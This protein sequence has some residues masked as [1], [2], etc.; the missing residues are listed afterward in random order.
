MIWDFIKKY[1]IDSI[2]YKTG[3]NPVNTAT[4]AAILIIAV[5][6][7]YR[8]LS[9]RLN[10]D[11]KFAYSNIPFILL[12]SSLRIFEDS[13][14]IKPPI[15]YLFMS[16]LIYL[17]TFT[18]AFPVLVFCLRKKEKYWLYYCSIGTILSS[19]S[20]TFLFMN[21]DVKNPLVAPLSALMALSL[22]SIFI[23][24]TKKVMRFADNNLSRLVFF[25]HMLDSSVTYIGISYFGYREIH[26][27][28]K[29]LISRIGAW[30][31]LPVKFLILL[32]VIAILDRGEDDNIKNFIKFVLIV[33][34][35]APALRDL[36]RITFYV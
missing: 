31:L 26:V 3:Y 23:L 13:G 32:A 22:T 21:L 17:L 8:Y 25:S 10:F 27:I 36:L 20:L 7:L 5:Y 28:P 6:F 33:L 15:S 16:P 34:G 30:S 4:W 14:F 19:S 24:L 2:V 29:I 18:I 9:K 35:L 11:E 1:Y 12:G